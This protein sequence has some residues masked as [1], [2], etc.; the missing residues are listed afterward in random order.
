MEFVEGEPKMT[1]YAYA[2]K[3]FEENQLEDQADM[4]SILRMLRP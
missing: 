4:V 2:T 1:A 3:E